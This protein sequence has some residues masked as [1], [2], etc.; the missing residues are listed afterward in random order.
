ML[1]NL[2]LVTLNAL[3]VCLYKFEMFVY[4][5]SI[6]VFKLNLS[7]WELSECNCFYW[8]K[9]YRCYHVVSV[10]HRESLCNFSFNSFVLS[11]PLKRKRNRGAKSSTKQALFRQSIDHR[12]EVTNAVPIQQD[13]DE[14]EREPDP[15]RQNTG[16][17]NIT[18]VPVTSNQSIP[19]DKEKC[20]KCDSTLQKRR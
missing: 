9:D 14:D 7:C 15:K 17:S 16:G 2:N 8:M 20:E 5:N 1:K 4:I 6:R 12:D 3:Y 13:S 19:D 11:L 18:I 10:A